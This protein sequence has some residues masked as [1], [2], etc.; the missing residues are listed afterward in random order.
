M[1]IPSPDSPA[2][3]AAGLEVERLEFIDNKMVIIPRNRGEH[4]PESSDA[5]KIVEKLR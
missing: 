1:M 5:D 3:Q 2:L 4:S